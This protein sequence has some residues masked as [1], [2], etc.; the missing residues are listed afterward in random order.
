MKVREIIT[1]GL[2]RDDATKI[3]SRFVKF[4]Q[5]ELEL[6]ELPSINL[7]TDYHYSV[8]HRSFGGY[9]PNDKSINVM[10]LNRHIQDLLRTLAH[11]LVHYRQ[12]LNDELNADSG[13]DGSPQE[14]EANSTAAVI[15]RKWGKLNPDIFSLPPIS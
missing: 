12:D 9:S 11:E 7:I 13:N 8:K 4:A 1:E 15:M 14:N 5:Q 2:K 3:I 10:M 6:D